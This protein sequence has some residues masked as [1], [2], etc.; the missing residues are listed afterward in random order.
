MAADTALHAAPAHAAALARHARHARWRL[1]LLAAPALLLLAVILLGPILWLSALSF[2]GPDGLTLAHYQRLWHGA[3]LYSFRTTFELAL[4]VT[5]LCALLAYPLCYLMARVSSRTAALLMLC[6]LL[7]FWTSLLVRTYAWL[8]LLQRRG[9]INSWLGDLGL[10]DT[11]LRLVHNF[12]GTAIGMTHI[13]LPFMVLP[14]YASMRAIAPDYLQAAAGLGA[15][16][17]QVFRQVYLPLSVPGLAAGA[18]LVFV[19]SLGFYVTPAVLGGGRVVMWS[20]QIERNI[21]LYGD[22]GAASALGV[23]LLAVTL[24]FIWLLARL[25][26]LE[27]LV[28]R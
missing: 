25:F 18:V 16:P 27:K 21:S 28:A 23:V 10:V 5:V 13:M 24:L 7:P 9:V 14:L 20:M 22:W 17:A 26:G 15:T 19:L 11:P 1:L 2:V 6:V 3:F 4:L 8:I 12:T